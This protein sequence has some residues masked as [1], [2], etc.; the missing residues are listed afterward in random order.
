M[1]SPI[2]SFKELEGFSQE[3]PRVSSGFSRLVSVLATAA[4]FALLVAL[5]LAA[6]AFPAAA[7]ALFTSVINT[8]SSS[9]ADEVVST[10]RSLDLTS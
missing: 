9:P 3:E 5:K 4:L 7:Q 10:D 2:P 6:D 1:S 8:T